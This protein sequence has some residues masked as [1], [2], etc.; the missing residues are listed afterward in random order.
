MNFVCDQGQNIGLHGNP[1]LSFKYDA[2][3]HEKPY[4]HVWGGGWGFQVFIRPFMIKMH[5]VKSYIQPSNAH[6]RLL[7]LRRVL[8]TF[9]L[10]R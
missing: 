6:W 7:V 10:R 4:K 8:L 1:I 2:F 3:D 9:G 5:L